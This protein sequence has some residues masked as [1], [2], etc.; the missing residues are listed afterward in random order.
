MRSRHGRNARRNRAT[1]LIGMIAMMSA[2]VSA[3]PASAA[4]SGLVYPSKAFPAPRPD[5][6]HGDVTCPD[7]HPNV[8]GGGIE[9]TRD[10]STLDLEAGGNRAPRP[11]Q[12]EGGA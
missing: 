6:T 10:E 9:I 3:T 8:T 4:G 12:G 7:G 11:P 1:L 2:T 5:V